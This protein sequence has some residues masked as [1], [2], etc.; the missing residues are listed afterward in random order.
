MNSVMMHHLATPARVSVF[1]RVIA[2]HEPGVN[3]LVDHE[4]LGVMAMF[5]KCWQ[6]MPEGH[7]IVL[8]DDLLPCRNL[9]KA[10]DVIATIIPTEP[11]AIYDMHIAALNIA[12]GM[13]TQ[14]RKLQASNWGGSVMLPTSWVPNMLAWI[15]YAL[16]PLDDDDTAL[17]LYVKAFG[18]FFWHTPPL[19]QHIGLVSTLKHGRT[20]TG[21]RLFVG[22][23]FDALSVDW[24]RGIDTA[25]TEVYPLT[26]DF[27]RRLTPEALAD[28][29]STQH[30]WRHG[31]VSDRLRPPN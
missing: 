12:T 11:V 22:E 29:D 17:S 20:Y 26:Q 23:N 3:V 16:L 30:S 5:R 15:D 4:G 28:Y 27:F 10:L 18:R 31:S 24:S 8:Q 9:M 25:Y 14:W 2:A 7:G 13:G 19:L 21:N 6:A 1:Q